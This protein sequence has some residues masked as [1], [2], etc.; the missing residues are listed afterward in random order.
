M[1]CKSGDV[2][3]HGYKSVLEP[4]L[5]AFKILK[6]YGVYVPLLGK[7]PKGT[8]LSFVADNLGVHG[9]AGFIENFSD[10][11][12]CRFCTA[13]SCD[14]RNHC[15]ATGDFSLRTREGHADQVKSSCEKDT[16]C[17]GVKRECIFTK[18]LSHFHVVS[19]FPPDVAHDI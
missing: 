4:L 5:Q 15:V 19:S 17:F 16:H 2:Q 9:I 7:S 3:T 6:Y 10:D 18:T 12:V 13:K 11:Y 1:L 8:I 14:F